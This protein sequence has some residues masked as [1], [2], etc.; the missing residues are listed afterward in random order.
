[1]PDK[2]P[3]HIVFDTNPLWTGSADQ[4]LSLR[5]SKLIKSLSTKPSLNI[6]WYVPTIVRFEREYQMLTEANTFL[7]SVNKAERLMGKSFG[8][9]SESARAQIQE[10]IAK[11]MEEHRIVAPSFDAAAV[12]WNRIIERAAFRIPPFESGDTEKGFRDAIVLETF[13]QLHNTLNL[14]EPSQLIL[15]TNDILLNSAVEERLKSS[16]VVRLHRNIESLETSL[17]ALSEEIDQSA[18]KEL[19]IAAGKFLN[20]S[21]TVGRLSAVLF[22]NYSKEL[23]TGPD[24]EEVNAWQVTIRDTAL[25]EKRDRALTFQTTVIV[26]TEITRTLNLRQNTQSTGQIN[27]GRNAIFTTATP[28]TLTSGTAGVAGTTITVG[29]GGSMAG[30]EFITSTSQPLSRMMDTSSASISLAEVI[31]VLKGIGRHSLNFLWSAKLDENQRLTDFQLGTIEY[32][33]AVWE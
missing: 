13:S 17:V 22:E 6:H 10:L 9:T 1:M 23:R 24:G 25:V 33:G 11:R 3:I 19:V 7:A 18:A 29:V 16:P 4:F 32:E 2:V 28:G 27:I 8:F 21:M 31:H 26:R 12:D 30:T 14:S 20:E 15:V 5:V